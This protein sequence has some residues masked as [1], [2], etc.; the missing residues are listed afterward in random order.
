VNVLHKLCL[1][2]RLRSEP[3]HLLDLSRHFHHS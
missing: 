2:V 1:I 3:Q